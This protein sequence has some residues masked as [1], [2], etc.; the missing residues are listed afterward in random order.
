MKK[1]NIINSISTKF[2]GNYTKNAIKE[3]EENIV[4]ETDFLEKVD[5]TLNDANNKKI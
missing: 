1:F 4:S 5:R 2:V 3:F